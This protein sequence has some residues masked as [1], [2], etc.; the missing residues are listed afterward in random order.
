MHYL[1]DTVAKFDR[2]YYLIEYLANLN[3]GLTVEDMA[4]ETGKSEKTIR[5][6]L[7]SIQ[8]IFGLNLLTERGPD[9]KF[10]Y[11]IEKHA[12]A[13]RPL[14][15]NI[16]E[17]LSLFFIRGFAH[18]K[19]ISFI[20]KNINEVFNKIKLEAG[21]SKKRSG[22]NFQERV[23]NLFI[24]PKE[25]GGKVSKEYD[26][27]DFLQKLIGAAIDLRIC[28]I[29]YGSSEIEKNY[30]IAPLHFFNYRDAIYLLTKTS[31]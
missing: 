22:N 29:A 8:A 21:E 14:V 20:Q 11:R 15:F 4:E 16:D 19:D 9:R 26:K 27:I 31:Y 2:I 25:L 23:S 12:V 5:R 13:F 7:S 30:R 10:R 17:I 6:D 3:S 18:F 24:L 28:D 1:E